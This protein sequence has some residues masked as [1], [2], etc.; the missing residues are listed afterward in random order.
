MAEP[1][2]AASTSAFLNYA[3]FA[4]ILLVR[5]STARM[6]ALDQ[7]A[8]RAIGFGELAEAV[9]AGFAEAWGV[10]FEAGELS[11]RER[12]IERELRAEKYT[13]DAWTFGR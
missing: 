9:V 3:V 5:P 7:A 4:A 1:A 12:A 13:S 6:I 8:G 2:A 11:G 10:A